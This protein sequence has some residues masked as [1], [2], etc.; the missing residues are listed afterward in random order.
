[1][2]M[3]LADW[4]SIAEIFGAFAI[5]VSLYFVGAELSEGN[6]ETRAATT[7]ATLDSAVAFNA[8]VLRYADV[9]EKVLTDSEIS[10][11][12]DKRRAIVLYNM[13]MTLNENRYQMNRSGYMEYSADSLRD[14]VDLRIHDAW[15]TSPGAAAHSKDFLDY[16][17]GLRS[18]KTSR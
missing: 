14:V 1:M 15:R 11:A 10:D 2:K 7:Q 6:R 16:V 8:E 3:R 4:A 12:V 9:W 17:D 5:V 13:M 18:Q